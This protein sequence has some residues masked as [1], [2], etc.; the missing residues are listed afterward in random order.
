MVFN[1]MAAAKEHTRQRN[2]TKTT[3]IKIESYDIDPKDPKN[4]KIVGYDMFEKDGSGVPKKVEVKHNNEKTNG[5]ADFANPQAL[6]HTQEGGLLRL[7]QFRVGG[8]G[9]YLTN[10]MQRISKDGGPKMSGNREKYDIAFMKG[11]T[12]IYPKK[13]AGGDL[14]IFKRQGRLYHRADVMVV[15]E[16]SQSTTMNFGSDTFEKEL[17]AAL[18]KVVDMA[19]KGAQPVIVVRMPG[20]LQADEIRL[21]NFKMDADQ[22]AVPLTKEEIIKN[23]KENSKLANSYLPSHR[24]AKD[25]KQTGQCE[26]VTGFALNAIGMKWD[27]KSMQK[28]GQTGE[29]EPKYNDRSL[30]EEFMSETAQ[31]H[32]LPREEGENK[33]RYVLD[34]GAAQYSFGVLS[35]RIKQAAEGEF[36]QADLDTFGRDHGAQMRVSPNAGLDEKPNP[37]QTAK[38]AAQTVSGAAAAQQAQPEAAAKTEAPAAKAEQATTQSAPAPKTTPVPQDKVVEEVEEEPADAQSD[39]GMDDFADGGF[40]VDMDDI[41][42]QLA[43]QSL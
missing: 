1:P 19:P 40:D 32:A 20:Q 3:V 16:D 41:E 42:S 5:I 10:H 11:W 26:F 8:D 34:D 12:K 2:S 33:T 27:G 43:G 38:Q 13:E 37:Y 28:N 29:D 31:R 39:F 7:S 17:D 21:S 24:Q 14:T 6:M 35:Y 36:V 18:N 4:A 23:A 15:P 25:A 9:T 22:K 30:I